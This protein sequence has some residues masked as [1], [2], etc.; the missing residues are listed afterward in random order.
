LDKK[1]VVN[2]APA[3]SA[4]TLLPNLNPFTPTTT[5]SSVPPGTQSV[6]PAAIAQ[7][8]SN[9]ASIVQ[10]EVKTTGGKKTNRH[11][12]KNKKTKRKY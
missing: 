5:Q 4:T 1:D 2:A 12:Q 8:I 11:R 10:P 3:I 7:P 9:L 6:I